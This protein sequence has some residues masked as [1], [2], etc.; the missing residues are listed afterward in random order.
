M[1]IRDL[2]VTVLELEPNEF[3]WVLMEAV[4]AESEDCLGYRP[5][6]S[7]T[8]GYADYSEALIQGAIAVR[9]AQGLASF[10]LDFHPEGIMGARAVPAVPAG[11]TQAPASSMGGQS[12]TG[13]PSAPTASTTAMAPLAGPSKSSSSRVTRQA[14]LDSCMLT[15]MHSTL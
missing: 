13:M 4:Q 15:T 11:A 6:D 8:R 5:V 12:S 7:S 3:H 14:S 10:D 2:A 9:A 1:A